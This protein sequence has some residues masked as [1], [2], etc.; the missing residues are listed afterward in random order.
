MG[1]FFLFEIV[2]N[3]ILFYSW[4]SVYE[5]IKISWTSTIQKVPK[6]VFSY[7]STMI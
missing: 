4:I 5:R 7:V 6:M 1:I 2:F 3:V